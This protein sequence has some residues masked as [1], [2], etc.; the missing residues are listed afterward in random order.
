MRSNFYLLCSDNV[1]N[2]LE[3]LH[4]LNYLIVRLLFYL[5]ENESLKKIAWANFIYGKRAN[6]LLL[7][8]EKSL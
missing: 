7:H 5:L 4:F 3:C 8:C 2:Y 1:D 6:Y